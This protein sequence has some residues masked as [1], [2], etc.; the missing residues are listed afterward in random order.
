MNKYRSINWLIDYEVEVIY[1]SS[2]IFLCQKHTAFCLPVFKYFDYLLSRTCASRI[3]VLILV[4]TTVRRMLSRNTMSFTTE[5]LTLSLRSSQHSLIK[6]N[7]DC[8]LVCS[9]YGWFDAFL[10]RHQSFS[11]VGKFQIA[12]VLV[13]HTLQVD[14]Y[15]LPK[16]IDIVHH[17][18]QAVFAHVDTSAPNNVILVLRD[19]FLAILHHD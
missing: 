3:F 6:S 13:D 17:V 8:R 14:F 19:A 4:I 10:D 7:D 15:S 9:L 18:D 2:W 12:V 16:S 1:H 11:I 5:S